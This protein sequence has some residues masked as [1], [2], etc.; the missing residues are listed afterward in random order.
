MVSGGA[1]DEVALDA[2]AIDQDVDA[3]VTGVWTAFTAVPSLT[4]W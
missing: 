1:V 4:R 3:A 2:R